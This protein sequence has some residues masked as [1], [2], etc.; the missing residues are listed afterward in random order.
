MVTIYSRMLALACVAIVV[1]GCTAG[2]LESQPAEEQQQSGP[3]AHV[4]PETVPTPYSSIEVVSRNLGT[5]IL[6]I[7]SAQLK[8]MPDPKGEGIFVYSPQARYHEVQRY[9][10]W[11]VI[12]EMASPLN[13]ATKDITPSLPWPR[14]A[15]NGVWQWTGLDMYS[16][17]EAIEIVFN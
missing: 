4:V 3:V 11:L 13:G 6:D 8:E 10:F 9:I 2:Q 12:E 7:E 14:E 1:A 15:P 17:T 16:A 5:N